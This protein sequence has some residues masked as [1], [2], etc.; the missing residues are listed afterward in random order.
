M[1]STRF[2]CGLP[3]RADPG[4]AGTSSR[5]PLA[6]TS[7]TLGRAGMGG[8][9]GRRRDH[10]ADDADNFLKALIWCREVDADAEHV[11]VGVFPSR[12]AQWRSGPL[13]ARG[14]RPWL[15]STTAGRT[16]PRPAAA[17]RTVCPPRRMPRAGGGRLRG[18]HRAAVRR[19]R[20]D[21]RGRTTPMGADRTPPLKAPGT[22]SGRPRPLRGSQLHR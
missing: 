4:W 22:G 21:P 19:G 17:A 9:P 8:R 7:R 20:S 16:P 10:A 12:D 2:G 3:S 15:A 14:P 6:H 18:V 5:V 13:I 1:S 11:A